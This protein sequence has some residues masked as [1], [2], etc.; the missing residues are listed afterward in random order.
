MLSSD[1]NPVSELDRDKPPKAM[2]LGVSGISL[3]DAEKSFF[4]YANPFGFILFQRNCITPQQTKALIKDLRDCVGR[5]HAPV[6]IDQEGGRVAR[7]K[8]PHWPEFPPAR[9]LGKMAEEHPDLGVEATKINSQLIGLELYDLGITVNCAPLADVLFDVTN[10]AIGDR[11]FSSDPAIVSDCARASADGYLW[12]GVLPV[13]KHIPGHGRT[14]VDPHHTQ[15]VVK[16]S[17]QELHDIDFAPFRALRDM[18][19]GMT[20]HII[21]EAYDSLPTSLSPV[22]HDVI[23]KEIGFDGLLI[24]DDLNMK[25]VHG[26]VEDL[27]VNSLKAGT[28]IALHCNGNMGEMVLVSGVAPPM[29]FAAMDRWD[30]AQARLGT[31]PMFLDKGGLLDRLDMLLGVA[32]LTV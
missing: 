28:D 30:R 26:R 15:S 27:V 10:N 12:S 2:I 21:F 1:H 3:T 6:L 13:I 23:R 9:M 4:R 19:L 25:G 24:S 17:K 5:P 22:M 20:C 14:L 31:P 11:A 8:P 18:P 7:L 32:A 16:A 29:S